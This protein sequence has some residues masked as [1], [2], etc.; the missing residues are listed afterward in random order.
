MIW[1]RDRQ[2]TITVQADV[3]A[4]A[5]GIDVTHA[6]DKQLDALR[7]E[8]PVGYRIQVGGTVEESAKGQNSIN[9]QM[10]IMLVVVLTL[11]M[12]QLQSFSRVMMVVLTAPLGLIGVVATLLLFGQPF[13]FVAMLGVIAMFGI[14]M[15]NSVILV[16]QI[17]QDI[18]AG[19]QRIDA[20]VGATVRRF[21]PITLTAAAAVLAPDPAAA[22]QLRPHGHRADGR[23]HQRHRAHAVLPAG[24]V[25]RLVPGETRRARGST[26]MT[27]VKSPRIPVRLTI[28][29]LV[30]ALGACAFAPDRK[31]PAA[32]QPAQY[33]VQPPRRRRRARA[34]RYE[35]GAQPVPQWWKRYGS[36]ELDALVEEGLAK[37]RTW[38]PPAA[39]WPPPASSCAARSI[40]P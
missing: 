13:G 18:G 31:P 2:P 7:Q 33:G 19:H 30:L 12:V 37:T 35:Q 6:L 14:I 22:Q 36:P 38:P 26:T 16:D 1:E 21:R 8:L 5:Q 24:A 10:P 17:E 40:H 4:G 28:L 11:L 29:P 15:R 9:A 34:Q 25:C 20:I 39:R 23:H 32:P 27:T 3:V